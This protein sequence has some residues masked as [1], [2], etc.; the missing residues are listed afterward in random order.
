M[1]G[2][3]RC[4]GAARAHRWG[5][6]RGQRAPAPDAHA[7]D[8]CADVCAGSRTRSAADPRDVAIG[9]WRT[10]STGRSCRAQDARDIAERA[11]RSAR[12]PA[13]VRQYA[14]AR[15]PRTRTD[16]A[17]MPVR[18]R[19]AVAYQQRGRTRASARSACALSCTAHRAR[20]RRRRVRV[21]AGVAWCRTR[22]ARSCA[23]CS[24]P[25]MLAT[26]GCLYVL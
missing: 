14:C 9:G 13:R 22:R 1:Q 19:A 20:Q 24:Q 16:S 8:L 6:G 21:G 25:A 2:F 5:F 23:P 4:Q 11:R 12:A 26:A 3:R 10:A 17:V 15:E 7:Y 18:T